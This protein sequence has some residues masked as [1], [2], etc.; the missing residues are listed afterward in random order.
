MGNRTAEQKT[1][2]NGENVL[3]EQERNNFLDYQEMRSDVVFPDSF[4][5]ASRK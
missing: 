5:K 3:L 1:H 2:T 4:I